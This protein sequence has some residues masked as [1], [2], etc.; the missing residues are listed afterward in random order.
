MGVVY[1]WQ[2]QAVEA[3]R[4]KGIDATILNPLLVLT[5]YRWDALFP[6]LHT[7]ERYECDGAVRQLSSYWRLEGSFGEEDAMD[8]RHKMEPVARWENF[9]FETPHLQTLAIKVLSQVSSV[10]MC[11][12]IWRDNV[13]PSR[14][15]INRS[16]E[17][18]R[19]SDAASWKR[20]IEYKFDDDNGC[21]K[22]KITTT[23]SIRKLANAHLSKRALERRNWAKFADEVREDVGSRLIMVSIDEILIDRC[24]GPCWPLHSSAPNAT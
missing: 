13:V 16:I 20:V 10:A 17:P 2:V 9:G 7:A 4:S 6:P 15:A 22:V 5:E 24:H 11:Q 21:N 1:D 12:E 14:E 23:T 19:R 18:S 3:V 8:C